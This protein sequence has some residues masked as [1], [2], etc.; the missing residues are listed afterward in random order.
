MVYMRDVGFIKAKIMAHL[1][2]WFQKC[3][4]QMFYTEGIDS[5]FKGKLPWQSDISNKEN[6]RTRQWVK[7]ARNIV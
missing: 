4:T 5:V 1:F 6:A 7:I 2:F 3:Y